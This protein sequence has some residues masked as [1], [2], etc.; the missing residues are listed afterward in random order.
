MVLTQSENENMQ[1]DHIQKIVWVDTQTKSGWLDEDEL[2]DQPLKVCT[3]G[4]LVSENS[5]AVTLAQSYVEEL[6]QVG[7]IIVIPKVAIL[8]RE[9]VI[10][11][12]IPS[13]ENPSTTQPDA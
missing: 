4:W 8:E 10:T 12:E 3:A 11:A 2:I 6:D 9:D 5:E 7:E 13:T 1:I